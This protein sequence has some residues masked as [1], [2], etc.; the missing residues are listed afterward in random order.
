MSKVQ[1]SPDIFRYVDSTTITPNVGLTVS[2]FTT[3]RLRGNREA[4]D[5]NPIAAIEFY[6]T[7]GGG[8]VIG[9]IQAIEQDDVVNGGRLAFYTTNL[10][11]MAEHATITDVGAFGVGVTNPQAKIESLYGFKA[12][13]TQDS[14]G[15]SNMATAFIMGDEG[16]P[17]YIAI[18]RTATGNNFKMDIWDGSGWITPFTILAASG[19]VGIGTETPST[20]LHVLDTT[21]QLRV[22]YDASNYYSTT[23]SSTGVVTFNAVGTGSAFSFS[24]SVGIGNT[25]PQVALEVSGAADPKI[26]VSEA[27][28]TTSY[29]QMVDF[30]TGVGQI[31][32]VTAT[33]NSTIDIDP[34]PSDGSSAGN[35]RIFRSTNTTG[36]CNIQ[37]F[38]GTNSGT[39]NANIAGTGNTYFVSNNGNFGV[40]QTSWGTDSV[41]VFAQGLGTAPSTSPTNAFQMYAADQAAGN[42]A[43]HFRTENGAVIKLY[44]Q[45]ANADTSG[46]TLAALET[47]VN[48]LKALLRNTGLLAT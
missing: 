21:E 17:D 41:G 19:N 36:G 8:N 24:D 33:G 48:E 12:I 44:Q 47:E 29:I 20:T 9:K 37:I 42:T 18:R 35:Y 22:G 46:A 15:A 34:M 27:S 7:A 2:S 3:L 40:R 1:I 45:T 13:G 23:V 6:N 14:A 4:M 31:Q 10:G 25:A 39:Q 5:S 43:P 11:S 30:S 16:G 28:S 38:L 26:R 32:K